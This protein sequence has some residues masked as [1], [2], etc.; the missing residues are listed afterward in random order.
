MTTITS[1]SG[2]AATGTTTP[3]T[4]VNPVVQSSNSG[5][6]KTAV[7]LSL[8]SSI[9]ATLGGST[10]TT[11]LYSA[12]G[13]LNTIAQAGNA[14]ASQTSPTS[15]ST[16]PTTTQQAQ[17]ATDE[18]ALNPLSPS[19][20]STS[21]IYTASGALNSTSGS[22]N[23]NWA[24]ILSATPAA[25]SALTADTANQSIISTISATA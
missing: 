11:P 10:S 25:A 17:T 1:T 4:Y 18:A 13:L 12:V 15:T 24:S 16:T 22:V 6:S 5:L 8:D 9:V 19:N 23:S 21:G 2:T 3:S 20:A 7:Q 14:S